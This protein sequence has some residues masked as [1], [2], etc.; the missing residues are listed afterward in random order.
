M[1]GKEQAG[2][3]AFPAAVLS[4]NPIALIGERLVLSGAKACDAFTDVFFSTRDS[5]MFEFD[6]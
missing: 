5:N 4:G 6:R 2:M 3:H 1:R